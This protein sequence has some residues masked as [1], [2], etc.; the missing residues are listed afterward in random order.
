MNS[1]KLEDILNLSLDSTVQEREKSLTLNVGFDEAEQTWELI[2]RFHGD[3]SRL[4]SDCIRIFC[5]NG[6]FPAK[7]CRQ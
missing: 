5:E 4:N 7:R 1:Q 6:S 2:V 3:L